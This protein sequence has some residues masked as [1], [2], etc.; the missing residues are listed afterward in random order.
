M[1]S[2]C[3][4]LNNQLMGYDAKLYQQNSDTSHQI[5]KNASNT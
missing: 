4:D 1:R 2:V 3:N 5:D